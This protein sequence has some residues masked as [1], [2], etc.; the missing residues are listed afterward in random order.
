[1][2]CGIRFLISVNRRWR[3]AHTVL[4]WIY[5]TVQLGREPAVLDLGLTGHGVVVQLAAPDLVVG[6]QAVLLFL[7]AHVN[8]ID[9]LSILTILRLVLMLR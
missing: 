1:M 2:L 6:N 7:Y 3:V 4:N 9:N 5:R 8:T